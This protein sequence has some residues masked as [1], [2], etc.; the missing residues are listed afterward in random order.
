MENAYR[1]I[2]ENIMSGKIDKNIAIQLM[3]ILKQVKV[4]S[5]E[6][7]A[8]TGIALKFPNADNIKDFWSNIVN[9][10]DSVGE[11]P[12]FR[13]EG[14]AEFLK[15]QIGNEIGSLRYVRGAYLDKISD[16]DYRF[17][18]LSHKEASL[19]DPSQRIF[20]QTAWHAI[21][22]AGYDASRLKGS[23]TGVYVGYAGNSDYQSMVRHFEPDFFGSSIVGNIPAMLPTRIAYILDLKGPTMVIDTACSSSAVSVHL[24]C[25]SIRNGECE[26]AIAGGVRINLFP[27]DNENL[28]LG[29]EASDGKTKTYDDNADGAGWG[30]GVAAIFLKPLSKAQKDGDRIYAVIKGSALNQD[31]DSIGITAPNS[32]SQAEVLLKAWEDAQINPST[33]SYIESHGTATSLGDPIEIEGLGKAFRKHTDKKQFC[34]IST[35]KT[36]VGH[37]YE[38]AG[39]AGIVKAALSLKYAVLPPSL[40]FS[41]PNRR[42]DFSNSP[43]YVNIKPRKWEKHE[44]VPRRCGVSAFGLSGTNCHIVLEEPPIVL[45]AEN[46]CES[47]IQVLALSAKS[48]EAL[49]TLTRCYLDFVKIE[50]D[51]TIKELCYSANTGREQYT[52]R[53]AMLLKNK[54]DLE[55]K[56]ERLTEEKQVE[57]WPGVYC[58]GHKIVPESKKQRANGEIT[59][60]EKAALE[61]TAQE[62]IDEFIV[63]GSEI[64]LGEVCN[65]FTN[66]ADIEWQKLYKDEKVRRVR[67]PGYPF[68]M[69][70]CWIEVPETRRELVEKNKQDQY[71][72]MRWVMEEK[73]TKDVMINDGTAIILKDRTG[74]ASQLISVLREES[75]KVIEVELGD[76]YEK[77]NENSY[78]VN[79]SEKDFL[80]LFDDIGDRKISQ[81]IHLLTLGMVDKETSLDELEECQ[82]NGVYCLFFMTR[83]ITS[84]N[85]NKEMDIVLISDYVNKVSGSEELIKPGNAMLFGLGK[86]VS[87]EH[88]QLNCRNIDI[89]INT[90]FSVIMSEIRLKAISNS[91]AYRNNKRYIEEF[92][93]LDVDKIEGTEVEIAEEGVYIIT[94][95][96]GG[97]G[98]EIA[99]LFASSSK[100][101]F[102]LINRSGMPGRDKWEDVL[103]KGSDLKTC[104]K[105]T[106]IKEI[107]S[108]GSQVTCL[109]AD[110]ADYAEMKN[111]IKNLR[112]TFGKING[113]VHGAGISN[114]ELII[115]RSKESLERILSAKVQGTW[116]L[117]KLTENDKLDFFIMFSSVATIFS[118]IGQCAYVAANSYMDSFASY[119]NKIG[120]RTLTINWTTWK[121]TGMAADSGFTA[122]TIF[123]SMTTL[124]AICAFKD[125]LG[126]Q[127]ERALI[128]KLN[129]DGG[130]VLLLERTP[131]R[132][133]ED[134]K[135]KID[136]YIRISGK[137]GRAKKIGGSTTIV[138]VK[139]TGHDGGEY[140]ETEKRLARIWGQNLGCDE[141]SVYDGFY[142]LGGDSIIGMKIANGISEEINR[143]VNA[144]ELLKYQTISDLSRYLDETIGQGKSRIAVEYPPIVPAMGLEYYPASSA[145]KR[146]F[147]VSTIEGETTSYN[148]ERFMTIVGPLDVER[149]ETVIRK[150][151]RRHEILRTTL[152]MVDG[153]VVQRVHDEIDFEI[154]C[155]EVE[156]SETEKI[157]NGFIRPFDLTQMPLFRVGLLKLGREKFIMMV[158][159]HHAV[160]DGIS[161]DIFIEEFASLYKGVELPELKIQYKDY[162][163]W[164]KMLQKSDLMKKQE[165]YWRNVFSGNLPVLS[166]PIDFPRPETKSSEGSKITVTADRH[167]THNINKFAAD[168][169]TTLYMVLLAVYNILLSKCSLQEDIVI[170]TPI[171]GRPLAAMDNIIGM[172][173]NTIAVRN[174]PEWDKT[175][176]EFIKEVK[177]NALNAYA[178]QDYQFEDLV[179]GMGLKRDAGSNPL[180]N[181]M[182]VLQN[183]GIKSEEIDQ[184]N[185]DRYMIERN[186][187]NFDLILEAI[188]SDGEIIFNWEYCTKLFKKETLETM[189]NDFM[190]LLKGLAGY[191]NYKIGEI[192]LE[193]SKSLTISDIE[194]VEEDVT[195]NF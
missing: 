160:T 100:A 60:R 68:A 84:L 144:V 38:C 163:V 178:N 52:Y 182:L 91:V 164:Q 53:L 11:F 16:F 33:L 12:D 71:Y 171:T 174:Y 93:I 19:M 154:S 49:F 166:L 8:I 1:Y 108:S 177:E 15:Q 37:L 51:F 179:S 151:V 181:V 86:V 117:D 170:G 75:R 189:I 121:E 59:Q 131:V 112:K 186:T 176:G 185:G 25:Q 39:M 72:T 133:S 45:Q 77:L 173:V 41:K 116:I 42:I 114:D 168:T 3:K 67:I 104:K 36:N 106:A 13:Q 90:D 152:E 126:K 10:M 70:H 35:V 14:I 62:K 141:I 44:D 122:D 146:M 183:V 56:L 143:P 98:L 22:D 147:I 66:G 31:G 110:V 20:L 167:L 65:L 118:M 165:D 83:A 4:Q 180:F 105:I 76:A 64:A 155:T 5:C 28:K 156:E 194:E 18:R 195:F 17:F 142:E 2:M 191:L 130:G 48:E 61:K 32:I 136:N 89:D 150:I 26:M 169:E 79:G 58:R 80:S 50:E 128:G 24:A 113:I 54:R 149:F 73:D 92:S 29:V 87:R 94:G 192:E 96:T 47:C 124:Q 107:E 34:A 153:E 69:E 193:S 115:N 78:I 145:Q 7:I 148:I 134:I 23:K 157:I 102:A 88:S 162:S 137:K 95:G 190:G 9:G 123:K 27:V 101:N 184:L 109:S 125:I 172:F 119:R 138:D 111:V 99:K 55:E 129:Y 187:T 132:L 81:V 40:N 6:G 63:T 140:T 85:M 188:E 30:E 97:I 139:L 158:D 135:E 175:F 57:D 120:K 43:V 74:I 103:S 159:M 21:E 46:S 82:K 161:M 127:V